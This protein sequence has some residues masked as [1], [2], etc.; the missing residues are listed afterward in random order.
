MDQHKTL[1][2]NIPKMIKKAFFY[3][4]KYGKTIPFIEKTYTKM[5][6]RRAASLIRF[7]I[8]IR[9]LEINI[10]FSLRLL[11]GFLKHCDGS[12][13]LDV[14]PDNLLWTLQL[15]IRLSFFVLICLIYCFSLCCFLV[16]CF[17]KA[18]RATN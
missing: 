9:L 10:L 11:I 2:V 6:N 3:G 13:I 12:K 16:F 17:L 8:F 7:T 5:L 4:K 14:V 18:C 1:A 15:L